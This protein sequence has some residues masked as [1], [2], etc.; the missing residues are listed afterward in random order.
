MHR[1]RILLKQGHLQIPVFS[2]KINILCSAKAIPGV[3]ACQRSSL[4]RQA[5]GTGFLKAV[6]IGF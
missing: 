1:S 2:R 5:A 4:F 6:F 3:T